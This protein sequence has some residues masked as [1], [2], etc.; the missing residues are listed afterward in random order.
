[1]DEIEKMSSSLKDVNK[2][3]G[4]GKFEG[5][6]LIRWTKLSIKIKSSASLCV[7]NNETALLDLK[8]VMDGLGGKV[9]GEDAEVTRKRTSYY[10]EKNRLDKMLA[11]CNLYIVSSDEVISL[12]NEAE[13]SYFKK[14]YL[15][16]ELDMIDLLVIY[17]DNPI[18]IFQASG[19]FVFRRSGIR[20]I[21]TI[22]VVS[23]VV[24]ILVSII[25]S[26]WLRKKLLLFE[27]RRH[28]QDDFSE[29]LLRAILTTFSCS[30]PYLI[31]S[32]TAAVASIAIT[33]EIS[34]ILFIT[35]F[36]VGLFLF[37]LATTVIRLLLLPFP[38]AKFFLSFAPHIAE[39]L[40]KRLKILVTLGLVGYLAFYTVFSESIV[41]SNLILMRN[42]FSLFFV[43]N[44]VWTLQVI[45][46][47]PKL[48]KLRYISILVIIAVLASLIAE[49]MGYRNLAFSSRQIIMSSFIVF[50]IFIGIAKI[51]KDLF[52]AVDDGTYRWCR[53]IH[54]TLGVESNE[55]VPGLIWLRLLATITVWGSFAIIFINTWDYSGGFL[56]HAKGYVVHGFDIGDFRI[57]PSRILWAV[58]LFGVIIILS[59]WVRSQ[60][61]HNWL[62][63]TTM[64]QG[65]RDAM[66][67]I[68]GYIMFLVAILVGLSAA[69]FDFSNIAIIAGALSVGIGFGLQNIVNN[70]VS[71][72]ILL[73]ERPIRKGDW[74]EVGG[75][76]G[77]VK[78]IH[79]RS[80]KIQT[81]DRSDVIVPNSELISNQV[82][83]WVLSSKSGRAIVPVGVAYGTDTEKVRD[84]LLAIAEENEDVSKAKTMPE[85]RVLFREFGDSSLNFELR[86]FLHNVD[87]RLSVISDL[88]FAID[89]A[90]RENNIEIP[91]PQRDLHVKTF[92]QS[93]ATG[94]FKKNN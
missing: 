63:M 23:S 71:G 78:D 8:V 5:N 35:E 94:D 73:F 39:K 14:K 26:I 24:A 4:K 17:L 82:T 43:V 15:A 68:I 88:N 87:S 6:D 85:P 32:M 27:S 36:F 29:N 38:P 41:E 69:G 20:E 9:K 55:K 90:F 59:S 16:R 37:F 67:T 13:K 1:M 10:K 83:N 22:D 12:V 47:S 81:F 3:L 49:W 25:F 40:A 76:E 60:L 31:G 48:P 57:V 52:D 84:I 2:K 89:K 18:A 30:A 62:K 7:S 33:F 74:I 72:L 86:V 70:F 42:I 65:A 58:L 92:P 61:E 11:K 51:F 56:E 28:W 45:I 79:I 19:D 77:Y 93:N 64:G 53:N 50:I 46:S 66:V 34:K 21:D 44:F 54:Q 80:T 91:F 75:T